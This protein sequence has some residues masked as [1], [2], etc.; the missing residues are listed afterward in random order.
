[1]AFRLNFDDT[2]KE[3]DMLS[4]ARFPNLL[5]NGASGIAIGLATNIPPH[6]LRECVNAVIAQIDNPEI[7]VDELMNI[8]PAPDFPTGGIFCWI[9]SGT[10]QCLHHGPRCLPCARTH[11]ED[12]AAGRKL[13]VIRSTR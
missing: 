12:G 8:M 4:P 5:V 11:M 2:L 6:N 7:T 9:R 3:P 13:I 10:S 1:M